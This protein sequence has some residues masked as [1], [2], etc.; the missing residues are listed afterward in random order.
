[1]LPGLLGQT[2]R[3]SRP[4]VV[5][6]VRALALAQPADAIRQAILRLKSRPDSTP[7][8]EAIAC[9]T[10]VVVGSEDQITTPEVARALRERIAGAELA[11]I[12]SAGH[13]SNF[14]RPEAFNRVLGRF[15]GGV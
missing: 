5:A 2:T 1:M 6:A 3:T 11:V 13:L 9:P 10:L 8:L 14:E 12:P 15:L 7:L 4:T